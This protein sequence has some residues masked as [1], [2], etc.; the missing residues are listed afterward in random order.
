M[1]DINNPALKER[2]RELRR[3]Q[4]PTEYALWQKIRGRQLS[5]YRFVRQYSVGPYIL[6]LYCPAK[7]L[8]IEL[9]GEQHYARDGL[10]YDEERAAYLAGF[11]IKT[12]RFRNKE[13]IEN[14]PEV[15]KS[16]LNSLSCL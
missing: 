15:L 7:K 12:L 1:S 11:G 10:A 14:L 16:I 8:G 3:N 9:D 4:T 2:R 5:N 13:V 6:D